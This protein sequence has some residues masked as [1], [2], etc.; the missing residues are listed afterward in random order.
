LGGT[1]AQIYNKLPIFPLS[2][3]DVILTFGIIIKRL[4]KREEAFMTD[5]SDFYSL[6]PIPLLI[7][8]SGPSGVGK[9][10]VLHTMKGRGLQFHFVVT[11]TTRHPRPGE[12]EGVDYFFVSPQRYAEMLEKDE[13]LEHASVYDDCYGIPKRQI[14]EAF[15]SGRDV[16]LRVDVQGAATIRRL[17][18][19]AVLAFLMP[20]SEAELFNR[21]QARKTES[22][23]S[24]ELRKATAIQEIGRVGEF[25]YVVVNA[26]GRLEET[27]DDILAIIR[28]E[29][30]RVHPRKATL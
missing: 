21:M 25:D 13:F 1:A 26:D 8:I 27:V 4:L 24:L 7:V 17:C 2:R 14:V 22:P 20:R 5:Q 3:T 23:E 29:H 18:P 12:V 10:S 9:D 11:V 15:A 28:S 30:C 16:V 19:E 6:Q